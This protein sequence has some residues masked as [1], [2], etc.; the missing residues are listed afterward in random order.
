MLSRQPE[1]TAY[2][3]KSKNTKKP[4][5]VPLAYN[6]STWKIEVRRSQGQLWLHGY[7]S[8]RQNRNKRDLAYWQKE[9]I[10]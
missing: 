10:P 2:L 3:L 1:I 8:L 9:L 7:T 6:F 4:G 5:M